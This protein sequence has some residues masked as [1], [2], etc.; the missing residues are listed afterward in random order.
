[1]TVGDM[2][3]SAKVRNSS[4]ILNFD[5]VSRSG[6]AVA[7]M[8][9]DGLMLTALSYVALSFA[10]FL[11]HHEPGYVEYYLYLYPTIGAIVTMVFTFARS[12]VYNV[13]NAF[14]P[15]SV[16]RVTVKRLVEVIL[17]LT[18]C[19]FILKVSDDFSRMWL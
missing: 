2:P 17:L 9:V 1:M 7:Q 8:A 14:D 13:F 5:D 18:G 6:I 16:L 15:I 3:I 12:G 11:E 19:F 10:I 4:R